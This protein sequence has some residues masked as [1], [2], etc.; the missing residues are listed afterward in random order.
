VIALSITA[1]KFHRAGL[2]QTLSSIDASTVDKIP[3]GFNNSIRWN[4]GH[5]LSAGDFMLSHLSGYQ[6]LLP[7]HYSD[8]FAR[9]TSPKE[10]QGGPPEWSEMLNY[11]EQQTNQVEELFN[12][13]RPELTK[14]LEIRGTSFST[15]DEVLA[16]IGGHEGQH[17]GTIKAYARLIK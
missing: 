16:F 1:F 3:E 15:V 5:I 9:G 2:I 12:N 8:F 6:R 7:A 14:P 11:L 10:W 17:H 13:G 4:V